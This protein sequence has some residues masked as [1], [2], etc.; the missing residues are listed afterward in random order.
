MLHSSLYVCN[1]L[2][3]VSYIINFSL[4][5]TLEILMDLLDILRKKAGKSRSLMLHQLICWFFYA[6]CKVALYNLSRKEK[7]SD[8][9]DEAVIENHIKLCYHFLMSFALW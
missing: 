4:S 2:N 7:K 6:F 5:Y 3:R 9:V 8:F 1:C